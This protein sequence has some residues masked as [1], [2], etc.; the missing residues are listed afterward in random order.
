[1]DVKRSTLWGLSPL[2][3]SKGGHPRSQTQIATL[4]PLNEPHTSQNRTPHT[5]KTPH[6]V[7]AVHEGAVLPKSVVRSALGG[8]LLS[9]CMQRA[10]ERELDTKGSKLM[11]RHMF[12]RV[13]I[14]DFAQYEVRE[15]G[16]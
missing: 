4:L 8:A 5:P 11:A 12:K 7:A 3:P 15:G 6:T 16:L 13:P 10:L 9:R 14:P 1:V 2:T